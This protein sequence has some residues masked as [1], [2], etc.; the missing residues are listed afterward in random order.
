MKRHPILLGMMVFA[1]LL[2]LLMIS[3]WAF[4]FFSSREGLFW[5][6]E[7]IAIIEVKGVILDPQPTIEKIVQFRKNRNV[8][9]IV[10][11]IDSPG[12][13]VG[14]AQEIYGEIK[15]A[16]REKKVL[17]SVG[18][19]AA[20][21]GYYIAC[22]A[23]KIF[24]NPGSIT[25]SIGVIIESMN[26]EDLLRKVGVQS[27]VVKSGKHKD[28]GSPFRAMT[29][30]EKKLLQ[31]VLDNVHDQFIQAVSEGRRLP[32]EKVRQ[33]ADGRI[34]SGEQGK[35]LGLVD[36]LG[37]LEDTIASAAKMAGIQGEPEVI[38][39]EKRRFSLLDFLLHETL[40]NFFSSVGERSSPHYFLYYWPGP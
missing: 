15:K 21:G 14:P 17:V 23:D 28:I 26:V 31:S 3:L 9:A 2:G 11:R 16:Q 18:S 39:P 12:G 19:M 13:A 38:Y 20:S 35:A 24:A 37:D 6:G 34:F 10:V 29:E 5:S 4:S 30:E 25:G 40:R 1:I 33:L 7:K 27:M 32:V 36:E 22:A 8:K